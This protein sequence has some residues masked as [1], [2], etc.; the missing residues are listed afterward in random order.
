[1][2]NILKRFSAFFKPKKAI[3]A[4]TSKVETLRE[5]RAAVLPLKATGLDYYVGGMRNDGGRLK[6][7]VV[8]NY[9]DI[10]KELYGQLAKSLGQNAALK[11]DIEWLRLGL[12]AITEDM[13]D[14][15][16]W[17]AMRKRRNAARKKR[18]TGV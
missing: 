17:N 8:I 3:V 12:K 1:V 11:Q 9:T 18:R 10:T 6:T 16:K 15:R 14:L 13:E 5:S 4:D 7:D 2:A